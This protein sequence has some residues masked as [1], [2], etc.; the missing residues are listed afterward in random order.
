MRFA[1]GCRRRLHAI[2]A[3]NKTNSQTDLPDGLT[4]VYMLA[5]VTAAV[6][7]KNACCLSNSWLNVSHQYVQHLRAAEKKIVGVFELRKIS[8]RKWFQYFSFFTFSFPNFSAAARKIWF[9]PLL[10][11]HRAKSVWANVANRSLTFAPFGSSSANDFAKDLLFICRLAKSPYALKRKHKRPNIA[12]SIN[13]NTPRG[14]NLNS[15][16]QKINK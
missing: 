10:D 13:K 4:L 8:L 11:W 15:K 1:L 6:S 7:S 5:F 12:S 14:P 2:Y 3:C 16:Q 9:A